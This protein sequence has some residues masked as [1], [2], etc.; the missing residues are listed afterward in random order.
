MIHNPWIHGMEFL[1]WSHQC[2]LLGSVLFVCSRLGETETRDK[3]L[4][5]AGQGLIKMLVNWITELMGSA[6]KVYRQCS[7][8]QFQGFPK[9]F[10]MFVWY[11][12]T[13]TELFNTIYSTSRISFLYHSNEE[14]FDVYSI[15]FSDPY[16]KVTFHFLVPVNHFPLRFQHQS[17]TDQHRT[18]VSG[19]SISLQGI[20]SHIRMSNG[21]THIICICIHNTCP[22][23]IKDQ[24]NLCVCFRSMRPNWRVWKKTNGTKWRSS[25]T[26]RWGIRRKR[27]N[28]VDQNFRWVWEIL[29]VANSANAY[30]AQGFSCVLFYVVLV[31]LYL[32]LW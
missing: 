20:Q 23:I 8:Y 9:V 29:F 32:L 15:L 28:V 26:E 31:C 17:Q 24:W 14:V 27:R 2:A 12:G 30:S 3:L 25:S 4:M 16:H 11:V 13:I 19:H 18:R 5:R 10:F 22:F 6:M 21:K 7:A 1:L